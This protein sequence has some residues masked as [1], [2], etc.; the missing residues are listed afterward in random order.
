LEHSPEAS[1]E[2]EIHYKCQAAAHEAN[3]MIRVL[4][5]KKDAG[6]LRGAAASNGKADEPAPVQDLESDD[7]DD[8]DDDDDFTVVDDLL[9]S[10]APKDG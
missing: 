4:E 10:F 8:D 2:A 7:D 5:Q 9:N 3:Y 1:V 6:G